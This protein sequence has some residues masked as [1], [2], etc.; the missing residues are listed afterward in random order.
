M[1]SA[2]KREGRLKGSACKIS[3]VKFK[4]PLNSIVYWGHRIS[5]TELWEGG[6]ECCNYDAVRA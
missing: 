5:Q 4:D 3:D 1:I 2:F 6:V